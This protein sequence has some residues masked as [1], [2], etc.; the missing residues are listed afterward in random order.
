[1]AGAKAVPKS[2]PEKPDEFGLNFETQ[3]EELTAQSLI[4]VFIDG[5][6]LGAGAPSG[7]V[8]IAKSDHFD[9][10][11]YLFNFIDYHTGFNVSV[12]ANRQFP[13]S[14]LE[15]SAVFSDAV[16]EGDES[17]QLAG[18]ALVKWTAGS[19][20]GNGCSLVEPGPNFSSA[21]FNGSVDGAGVLT[22]EVRYDEA[23]IE[24]TAVCGAVR[25]TTSVTVARGVVTIVGAATEDL[26]GSVAQVLT[27]PDS[28][29][30]AQPSVG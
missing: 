15:L 21:V 9:L 5:L 19:I 17:G 30:P 6:S 4:N 23:V 14:S 26:Q 16:L 12:T 22:L 20:G 28:P 1:L 7:I 11:E 27:P 29:A 10:G 24:N 13:E 18:S 25:S 2:A 3:V 8:D